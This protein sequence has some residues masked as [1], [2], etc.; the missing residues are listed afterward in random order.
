[1][2]AIVEEADRRPG[3]R[4]QAVDLGLGLHERAHMVVE[5]HADSELG[6][7]LRERGEFLP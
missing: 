4:H 6:H 2:A 3:M 5:G 1:M 7:A